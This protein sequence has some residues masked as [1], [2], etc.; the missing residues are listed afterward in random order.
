MNNIVVIN[1]P[2]VTRYEKTD[3]FDIFFKINFFFCY[4]TVPKSKLITE[5]WPLAFRL[6]STTWRA[7]FRENVD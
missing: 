4:R 6:C 1:A 2:Y 7:N 3:H 5:I